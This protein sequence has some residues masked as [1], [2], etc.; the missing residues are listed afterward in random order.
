MNL[1][2]ASITLVDAARQLP[3]N[4]SLSRAIKR[5]EKRIR[6]LQLR[7]A[8]TRRRRRWRAWA[9]ALAVAGTDNPNV[10][11]LYRRLDQVRSLVCAGCGFRFDFGAFVRHAELRGRGHVKHLDC[12]QCGYG[13][14]GVPED[15]QP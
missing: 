10:T 12:P 5:M 4:P 13:I 8:K 6:V 3:D 2:D 11:R 14:F 15:W 9:E 7:A 1:L